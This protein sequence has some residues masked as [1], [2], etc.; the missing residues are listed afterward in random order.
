MDQMDNGTYQI[1]SRTQNQM[2]GSGFR[3]QEN[4]MYQNDGDEDEDEDDMREGFSA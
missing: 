1:N 4:D 2:V 3:S